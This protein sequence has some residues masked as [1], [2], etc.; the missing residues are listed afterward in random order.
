MKKAL[1]PIVALGI[2]GA[3][4]PATAAIIVVP[5]GV[6]VV[7]PTQTTSPGV[8]F[9]AM[10]ANSAYYEFFV[11]Q[12]DTLTVSSF[13]NS[14]IATTGVFTFSSIGLYSGTGIGG[15]LLQTGTI[16]PRVD[17]TQTASL[18]VYNLGTGFYTIAYSGTVTGAP[19]GVGSNITFAA[20]A[21]P[22]PLSWTMMLA[23]FGAIGS[24]L[25]SRRKVTVSIDSMCVR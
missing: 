15:P 2:L 1:Y 21:I 7:P 17:G 5:L 9:P 8:I 11:S 3:V 16:S 4:A 19:S 12:P 22:E 25:R 18:G 20:G 14:A 24:A 23:G 6:I 10:G 13:T